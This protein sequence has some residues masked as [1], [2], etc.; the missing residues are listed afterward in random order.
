MRYNKIYRKLIVK[1]QEKSSNDKMI[2]SGHEGK[3]KWRVLKTELKINQ[4]REKIK[5]V[6]INNSVISNPSEIAIK[7]KEHFE[8]CAT[9]LANEVPD[10]GENEI[11]FEQKP[12]W[13][14]NV[15]T[16][17]KLI[18]TIDS[19]LPKSCCGFD[20]LSNRMLKKK[21]EILRNF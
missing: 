20:L 9:K 6:H 4:S 11:L 12:D 14:F 10:S 7:F 3:K 1:E 13:G 8:T 19:L 5:S 17:E 2:E 16:E 18:K 21:K 15:I